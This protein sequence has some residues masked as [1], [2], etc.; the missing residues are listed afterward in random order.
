VALGSARRLRGAAEAEGDIVPVT[1]GTGARDGMI[2]SSQASSFVTLQGEDSTR[3]A[4]ESE[5]VYASI[6]IN[7]EQT[8]H[9]RR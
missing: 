8:D 1:T 4:R 3:S 5:R 9:A 7:Q 6:A 2:G